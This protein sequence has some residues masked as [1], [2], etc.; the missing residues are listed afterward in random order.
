MA[1]FV[2]EAQLHAKGGD[3]GAGSVSFRR[4]A[5]V[6]KGGPDGGDGGRGGSVWLVASSAKS[7]LLAFKD[8]PHRRAENGKHGQGHG[9]HGASADDVEVMVPLGTVVK[10]HDGTPVADLAQEGMH[11]LAA[12]GGRGGRGNAR[13]L[14]NK[15]RAPAFAEQG[16]PG[17]E[18]WYNLELRLFADVALVGFPNAGKSTFI[19]KVSAAKPKIADYPFTTLEPN[20]GVVRLPGDG[21]EIVIADIPG[22]IEGASE[23]KGLGHRFLRHVERARVLAVL[24]DMSPF[25][26]HDPATQE[27]ILLSELANYKPELARRPRVVVGSR[28]DIAEDGGG[29]PPLMMSSATGQGVQAVLW[30]LARA[31]EAQRAIPE[32]AS[33]TV[34]HRIVPEGIEVRRGEDGAWEVL[35]RPARRA[36]AVSDLTDADALAWVHGRLRSLGVNKALARQGAKQGD[37]VRVGDLSFTWEPD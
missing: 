17:E 13:F 36:V 3:G 22:L 34:L 37:V 15:R 27:Q 24:V 35:G 18:H 11:W 6:P 2:D 14:S 1:G 16:E 32:A 23:G 12:E 10:G 9:R 25:A 7:T 8:H 4:E 28:V 31:L 33:P 21:G 5:H 26:P 29:G 19:S 20:L 30:E